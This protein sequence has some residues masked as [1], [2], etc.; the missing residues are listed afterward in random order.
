LGFHS[1]AAR[2]L[3]GLTV[4]LAAPQRLDSLELGPGLPP[5][6]KEGIQFGMNFQTAT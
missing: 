5:G 3:T 6:W 1:A 2:R 4:H